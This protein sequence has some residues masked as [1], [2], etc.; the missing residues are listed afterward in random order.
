[1]LIVALNTE[2]TGM[3]LRS[4]W[5][6]LQQLAV[7]CAILS[8]CWWETFLNSEHESQLGWQTERDEFDQCYSEALARIRTILGPPQIEGL[9]A[10]EDQ[11]RYAI[12]R[13]RSGLLILQQSCY[14]PQFGLDVNYWVQPWI[15]PDP[16]PT[17]PFIDW[18]CQLSS[19]SKPPG[20]NG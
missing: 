5:P 20:M 11:H 1:M 9:D 6:E 13:G 14:D 17:S 3:T 15:G 7:S 4:G 8:I 10:T 18:L 12:W 16:R 2:P 19:G